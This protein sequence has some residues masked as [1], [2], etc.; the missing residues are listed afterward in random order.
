[1]VCSF[2]ALF[3]CR[4]LINSPTALLYKPIECFRKQPAK[5]IGFWWKRISC[6][7]QSLLLS[8]FLYNENE[9]NILY[10]FNITRSQ[11]PTH[12]WEFAYI[13]KE[14]FYLRIH[15]RR[16]YWRGKGLVRRNC[17]NTQATY[18]RVVMLISKNSR[19]VFSC[20]HIFCTYFRSLVVNSYLY[21]FISFQNV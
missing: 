5:L 11:H 16:R 6:L 10:T 20:V 12:T 15:K 1:M 3:P 13:L 19:M 4:V 2:N 17:Y 9:V 8:S 7:A 14:I 21:I 18:I